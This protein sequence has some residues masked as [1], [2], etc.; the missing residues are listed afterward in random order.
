MFSL[1]QLD[2]VSFLQA[3]VK[4]YSEIQYAIMGN[5]VTAATNQHLTGDTLASRVFETSDIKDATEFDRAAVGLL[6]L[7][8]VLT[9]DYDHFTACQN[10]HTKLSQKS[11]SKLRHFTQQI[12][13]TPEDLEVAV[14]MI[15]C[16][17]L[18]KTHRIMD[19]YYDLEANKD[20]DHDVIFSTVLKKK[21][22]LFP[23]FQHLS[24][25]QKAI[26][27]EGLSTAFNLGQFAQGENTPADLPQIQSISKKARDLYILHAF[28]DIAGAAGHVKNNGSL[29]MSEPVFQ[30]Y[31][32]AIQSLM[33]EPFSDSYNRYVAVRGKLVG[34][35]SQTEKGFALSRLASLSRCFYEADGI[36]LSEVFDD[37]PK[38]VQ[39]ILQKELNETGLDGTSAI[40]IYYAPAFI[41]NIKK[42]YLGKLPADADKCSKRKALFY[43]YKT[44]FT[45]LAQIYNATRI[46]VKKQNM[47]GVLTVDINQLAKLALQNTEIFENQLVDIDMNLAKAFGH[48]Y[49]KETSCL[50]VRQFVQN[51]SVTNLLPRG[52]TAYIGIGGGSDCIQAGQLAFLN[53]QE[54]TCIISV[55]TQKTQSQGKQTKVIGVN[56]QIVNH[57]GEIATGVYK[58][59]PETTAS[60]R[61][62]ENLIADTSIPVYVVLDMQDGLLGQKIQAAIQ[63][64]GGADNIVSV[65]TGGDSLYLYNTNDLNSSKATPDQDYASLK[66][67]FE[68]DGYHK[69]SVVL[70]TGVDSPSYAQTVL[71]KA[72]AVFVPFT[73]SEK[74]QILDNY[75]Q[76]G[77][78]GTSD[79]AF[80]KTPLALQAALHQKRG[81]SV[82]PLPSEVVL[83]DKNPWNP[84]VVVT[85]SM[86]YVAVMPL[87][88]HFNVITHNTEQSLQQIYHS[89]NKD[90]L[91]H[92]I[93][94]NKQHSK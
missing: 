39:N 22:D 82:L 9:N 71:E 73:K 58:V 69:S 72:S 25:T 41:D 33:T 75:Q 32:L 26:I 43:A 77:M 4:K 86:Q 30:G 57:G 29:V 61:F 42:C 44:A 68:L 79:S 56:R 91:F 36:L 55:R 59:L 76:W 89:D 18:G 2:D 7:K 87:E 64:A 60:G 13:Q 12:I 88:N 21:E 5:K 53:P 93:M 49:L 92:G 62:M 84:F 14:Y 11:F 28:Y 74:N 37:L 51:T 65:D 35:N 50:D 81:V 80:G 20:A 46:A 66:A 23:G 83:D 63:H 48:A 67:L 85:D 47:A 3:V 52:K 45:T 38:N 34:F 94:Q 6:C 40:L 16:N 15:M 70:A 8:Y 54:A 31:D 78:D 17:D 10:P 1:L 24:D 19:V 90:V 27:Q